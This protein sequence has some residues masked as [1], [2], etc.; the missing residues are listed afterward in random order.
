M[1]LGTWLVGLSLRIS[2]LRLI[3]GVQSGL[4]LQANLQSYARHHVMKDAL[5]AAYAAT[6]RGVIDHCSYEPFQVYSRVAVQEMTWTSTS[7]LTPPPPLRLCS[8]SPPSHLR[9]FPVHLMLGVPLPN[10]C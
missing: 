2:D 4:P 9:S 1:V 8:V 5:A 10:L 6:P 7:V 3:I